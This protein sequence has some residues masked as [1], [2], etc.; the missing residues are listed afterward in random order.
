MRERRGSIWTTKY[1]HVIFPVDILAT[2]SKDAGHAAIKLVFY[3]ALWE[4]ATGCNLRWWT[5]LQRVMSGKHDIEHTFEK[6][7]KQKTIVTDWIIAAF[8]NEVCGPHPASVVE[9]GRCQLNS[10]VV[11]GMEKASLQP[12]VGQGGWE[13]QF[14]VSPRK[15]SGDK[16]YCCKNFHGSKSLWLQKLFITKVY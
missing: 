12:R 4:E 9:E 14:H 7:R 11:M 8:C 15:T 6:R 16:D 2:L 3:T 13:I 5:E 1:L 10:K